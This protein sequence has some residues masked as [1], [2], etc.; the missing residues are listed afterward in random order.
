MRLR[1]IRSHFCASDIFRLFP[2]SRARA[3]TT[4]N[5]K[6]NVA[7]ARRGREAPNHLLVIL[8]RRS[9]VEESPHI[10]RE[11][12]GDPSTSPCSVQDD[13]KETDNRMLSVPYLLYLFARSERGKGRVECGKWR[14]ELQNFVQ[15]G[16]RNAECG[17]VDTLSENAKRSREERGLDCERSEEWGYGGLPCSPLA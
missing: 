2:S 14:V 8:S 12:I 4:H 6:N 13:K 7:R 5:A 10:I 17:I 9:R 16:M 1:G 15:C 3:S 11:I